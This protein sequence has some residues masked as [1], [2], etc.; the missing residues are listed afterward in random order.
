[1]SKNTAQEF[2]AGALGNDGKQNRRGVKCLTALIISCEPLNEASETVIRVAKN[3]W[4]VVSRGPPGC[5]SC[6]T[7][8]R[9]KVMIQ[10]Q[11]SNPTKLLLIRHRCAMRFVIHLHTDVTTIIIT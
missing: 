7:I 5:S 4:L 1:M 10:R 2:D 3:T 11:P 8:R 6:V 9:W